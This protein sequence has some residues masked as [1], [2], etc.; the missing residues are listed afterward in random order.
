[1]WLDHVKS[2]VC[3]NERRTEIV[4]SPFERGP[5]EVIKVESELKTITP[6]ADSTETKMLYL[7]NENHSREHYNFSIYEGAPIFLPWRHQNLD[8]LEGYVRRCREKGFEPEN[9]PD[10]HEFQVVSWLFLLV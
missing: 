1:M 3:L 8:G 5:F 7:E 2:V 9:D 10:E 4:D 6:T